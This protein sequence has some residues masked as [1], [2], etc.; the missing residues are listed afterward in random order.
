[1]KNKRQKGVNTLTHNLFTHRGWKWYKNIGDFFLLI[2]RIF[3]V[4]K[5]GYYPQALWETDYWFFDVMYD[6]LTRYSEKKHEEDDVVGQLFD[7]DV[8]T[9]LKLIEDIGRLGVLT[10]DRDVIERKEQKFF[11]LFKKHFHELWD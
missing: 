9:M 11:S 7:K 2:K 10:E 5:H 6:I 1:M 8:K 4:I 3:F